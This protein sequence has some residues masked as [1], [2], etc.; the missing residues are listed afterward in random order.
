MPNI[1]PL[2]PDEM[3]RA[4]EKIGFQ[5]IRQSGSHAVYRHA[6]GRWATVPIHKGKEISK[7]LVHK[8]IKDAQLTW[9]EFEPYL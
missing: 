1:R 7:G 9:G 2:K 4:L 6:D 3:T 8:I 5:R